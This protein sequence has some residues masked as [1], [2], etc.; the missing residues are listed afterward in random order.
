[1][2]RNFISE[3]DIEQAML[4]RLQHLYGFDVLDCH[5]AKPDE[6]SD[7]SRRSD[8]RDVVLADRLLAAC[9]KLN[10]VIPEAV[11]EQQVIPKLM[12]RRSTMSAIAANREGWLDP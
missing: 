6:L 10:P 1:M 9:I 5:T 7:G 8:K 4:Q 2:A 12:D 3:D 11:I